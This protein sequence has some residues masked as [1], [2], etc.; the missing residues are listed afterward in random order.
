MHAK[1]ITSMTKSSSGSWISK[2]SLGQR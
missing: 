1:E 2:I